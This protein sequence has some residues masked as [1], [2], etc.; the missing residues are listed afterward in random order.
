MYAALQ[1]PASGRIPLGNKERESNI[2]SALLMAIGL[3]TP[4]GTS[5]MNHVLVCTEVAP[6]SLMRRDPCYLESRASFHGSRSAQP[7]GREVADCWL[8]AQSAPLLPAKTLP[9]CVQGL[10]TSAS[11]WKAVTLTRFP[12]LD[13]QLL[14]HGP[15]HRRPSRSSAFHGSFTVLVARDNVLLG[16]PVLL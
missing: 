13:S 11:S 5:V 10:K 8:L 9:L 7:C 1:C 15:G 16:T 4:K 3:Q 6:P 12:W 2:V 14:W